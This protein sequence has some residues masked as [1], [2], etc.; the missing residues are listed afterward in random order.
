[1]FEEDD[2]EV[3]IILDLSQPTVSGYEHYTE[4][5]FA[6][7]LRVINK[8]ISTACNSVATYE[9]LEMAIKAMSGEFVSIPK[10][11]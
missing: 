5:A 9:T 1:M 2:M 4:Q 10:Y 8:E 6:K 7:C 11:R 3:E